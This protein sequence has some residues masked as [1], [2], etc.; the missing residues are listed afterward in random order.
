MGYLSLFLGIGFLC[1]HEQHTRY[2]DLKTLDWLTQQR[3]RIGAIDSQA[4][5]TQLQKEFNRHDSAPRELV[6][7]VKRASG[8]ILSLIGEASKARGTA[9]QGPKSKA[10]TKAKAM[11]I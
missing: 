11:A 7:M 6:S 4:M 8:D 1:A 2:Q 3:T 5:L 9:A 10:K